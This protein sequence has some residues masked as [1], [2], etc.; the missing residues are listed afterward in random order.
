M[1]VDGSDKNTITGYGGHPMLASNGSRLVFRSQE[2]SGLVL[3][4]LVTWQRKQ[5]TFTHNDTHP[6]ISHDG[7]KVSFE[8]RGATYVWEKDNV[9]SVDGILTRSTGMS[10]VRSRSSWSPDGH[11]L[12][13]GGVDGVYKIPVSG[14]VPTKIV[15]NGAAPAWSSAGK[16]AFVRGND[17]YVSNDDGGG[18]LQLTDHPA[19]DYDPA[20]S[21]DGGH[22]VFVSERRA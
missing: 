17:I 21:P 10:G 18:L 7:S 6:A 5:I 11:W 12:A 3:L 1:N 16:I 14:G 19:N 22:I 15:E 9:H 2:L 4:D 13:Y 20:W 8:T